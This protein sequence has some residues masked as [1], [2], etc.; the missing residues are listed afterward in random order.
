MQK[1]PTYSNFN[2]IRYFKPDSKADK[3]GDAS[4]ISPMA[5]QKLDDL[6]HQL[7]TAVF[8]TSGYR[9]DNPS[10][11]HFYG[12]AFDIIV[13]GKELME[14]YQAAVD[15]GFTGI[16]VYPHWKMHGV[17]YG[18]LHVDLRS[19]RARWM[20]VLDASS[21]QIYIGFNRENLEK[22]GLA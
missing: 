16:G 5:L 19:G 15:V 10:S 4:K 13:P 11:Q 14:V 18:G 8:V 22:Y 6:R 20:G 9:S 12:H 1:K 7:G 21:K 3:W 17:E 2:N